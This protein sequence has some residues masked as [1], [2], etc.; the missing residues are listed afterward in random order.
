METEHHEQRVDF[1]NGYVI[2]KRTDTAAY[3]DLEIT[4]Y[5]RD[6]G[7][8]RKHRILYNIQYDYIRSQEWLWGKMIR[9]AIQGMDHYGHLQMEYTEGG[10]TPLDDWINP[11][12]DNHEPVRPE[13]ADIW[14]SEGI[15][16]FTEFWIVK[17]TADV[18]FYIRDELDE[19]HRGELTNLITG[20]HPMNKWIIEKYQEEEA[21]RSRNHVKFNPIEAAKKRKEAIQKHSKEIGVTIPYDPLFMD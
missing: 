8:Y 14:R 12:P 18:N 5:T 9:D 17:K 10:L 19:Y 1:D 6:G 16:F 13:G 20:I 7:V 4:E 2:A 11:Y 15:S 21:E 3:Q